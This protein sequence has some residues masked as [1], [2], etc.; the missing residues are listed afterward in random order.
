LGHDVPFSYCRKP[1]EDIPCAKIY[2]CWWE[3]FDIQTFMSSNYS[4]DIIQ[5]ITKPPQAKTTSLIE[6]IQQIQ[7]RRKK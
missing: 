6:M 7:K 2:D 3:Q 5:R 1:G 4:Q